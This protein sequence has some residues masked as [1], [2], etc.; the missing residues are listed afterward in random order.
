MDKITDRLR[1]IAMKNLIVYDE[2][3]RHL[4]GSISTEEILINCITR[5]AEENEALR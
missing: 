1:E 3:I 4:P 2:F 5:L